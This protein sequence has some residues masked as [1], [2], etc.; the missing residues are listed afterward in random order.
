MKMH[1]NRRN[2]LLGSLSTTVIAMAPLSVKANSGTE[3]QDKQK[4][5]QC[6]K[7]N[8]TDLRYFYHKEN[9]TGNS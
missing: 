3:Q 2:F 6:G 5:L 1:I 7:M 4:Y 8:S 9:N